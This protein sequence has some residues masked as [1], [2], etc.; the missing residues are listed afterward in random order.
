MTV[1]RLRTGAVSPDRRDIQA[2]P[3][4]RAGIDTG[5]DTGGATQTIA[6]AGGESPGVVIHK[7]SDAAVM[8][9]APASFRRF[10]ADEVRELRAESTCDDGAVGVTVWF[11]RSDGYAS[12]AVNDCGGYV[13]L[14]AMVDGVWTEIDGTQE[15]WGCGVLEEYAVPSDVAG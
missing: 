15:L 13:A 11:V 10:I 12:G 3:A 6:Y 4:S 9:D 1:D 2:R 5:I 8:T 14:W 7:P